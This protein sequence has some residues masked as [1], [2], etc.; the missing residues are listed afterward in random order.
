MPIEDQLG[1]N[2]DVRRIGTRTRR[3]A[4]DWS[5]VLASQGIETAIDEHPER[6]WT[7]VVAEADLAR[8]QEAIEQYRRENLNW[9]WRREVS[10]GGLLFDWAAALW[11]VINAALFSVNGTPS[12][13]RPAGAMDVGALKHGE[14]WRLFTAE[15]LHA[16]L[17]HLASNGVFGLLLL[18]F[19]LGRFGTGVGLLAAYLAGT[20]GNVVS[21][22]LH[23]EPHRSL[24]ASGVVMGALGLLAAQSFTMLKQNPH[25]IRL[26]F[27]GVA[28]GG[29]L[30]MLL[31][32]DP[33]SDVLAH[34]GGFFTG[35][36]LAVALRQLPVL[37]RARH[38]NA[39]AASGLAALLLL[40]WKLAL[41]STPAAPHN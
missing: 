30:F 18:G 12:D 6:G 2:P 33:R 7:L 10:E 24:G 5:L 3:R 19:A 22:L 11:V 41:S 20:V 35:L 16:D 28:G 32:L 21:W 25:A 9:P 1:A 40:A 37:S 15:W 31:G 23:G 34:A 8:A 29:M 4:M 17:L 39:I 27:G 36:G 38:A 14:W 26:A 13:L